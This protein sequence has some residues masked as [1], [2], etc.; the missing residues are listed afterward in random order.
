M[1]EPAK[2]GAKKGAGSAKPQLKP[3]PKTE[4]EPKP[5]PAVEDK[6]VV[7]S[8]P[9]PTAKTPPAEAPPAE[10]PPAEVPVS[11]QSPNPEEPSEDGS[12]EEQREYY[13]EDMAQDEDYFEDMSSYDAPEPDV[14]LSTLSGLF[15]KKPHDL[16]VQTGKDFPI[17]ITV[18][19]TQLTAKP[20][21]K[22]FKGKWLE[23][24]S[25]SGT[26]YKFEESYEE[27]KKLY[28]FELKVFKAVK[29]DN[30]TYRC[31]VCSAD[32]RENCTF[33]VSV[34]DAGDDGNIL[35]AFKRSPGGEGKRTDAGELDFSALLKK[36]EREKKEKEEKKVEPKK[37]E[38]KDEDDPMANIPPHVLEILRNA[39]PNEYE[40]IAFQHGITDLRGM[41]KHLKKKRVEIQKTDAF[42]R[43]LDNC[44]TVDR[45]Q[46]IKIHV[47]VSNPDLPVKWMKNG[48][49]IKPSAK[50]VFENIGL[51]RI[52]TINK[53]TLADDAEYT[54]VVGD[55]RCS[56]ELFV[57][58]PPVTIEKPLED[59]QAFVGDKVE[60]EVEVSEEGAQVVWTK[61][62]I[63]LTR[64]EMTKYRFR[65]DGKKH[66]LIINETNKEDTG[67]Y[68]VETNGG[69]CEA[70][71]VI[72]DK[73]LEVLQGIAD[74]TVKAAEQ[75]VFKCEVSDEK[76]TG[77]WLKNG[78]EI[79]PS[80]R[81]TMS[82]KGR[83]HKLVIDDVK[84][85]DE[86]DYTFVP[87]GYALSLSA[88]L[89]F[90]EV[91]IEYVPLEEPPKIHL[92][93]SGEKPLNTIT[94]VAGNKLRFDV[95][96]TGEPAPTVTWFKEDVE[97]TEIDGRVRIE[98][99]PDLSSFVIEGA[100]R[101][102]EGNYKIVV[103]N[104]SGEDAAQLYVKVVD[105]PDPPENIT[106]VG[107]GEDWADVVWDPPKYDGG[108]EILGYYIER[109]KKGSQR[110]MKMNFEAY[111]DTKYQSTNM[112]EGVL[113][114]IRIFAVNAIGISQEAS[115]TNPFMPIAPTSEPLHLTVEDVT[116]TT[117]TLKWRPPDRIGAG[118]I[119]G[120]LIEY[121]KEGTDEWIESNKEL[122][123]RCGYTA[124]GLPTGE[125][126][127]FRVRAVNIAGKSEP[128][129]LGQPVTIREIVQSPKIRLPRQL[130]QTYI[131]KVGEHVN[132]VIPFQGKP[133]P[134]VTWTKDGEPLDP[135]KVSVRTS[136]SDTIIFIRSSERSH[137]GKYD[138]SVKIENMV[139]CATVNIRIV[140]KPGPA[141][142]VMVKEVWGF[143]ALVEWQPPKDN[144]NSEITGYSIQKADKKTMEW[145]T[146]YEHNRQPRCTVSDLI[147]GNEYYFRVYSENIVGLSD[148]PGVSKNTAIIEKTGLIHKPRDYKEMDVNEAPKFL[149]PLIDR[150]VVAGY[151][152]ALNCAV[153]GHPKPKV[154]WMKNKME[155][156]DDPKFLMKH[157]QGVLTLN[158]RKPS[159]FDGG[160]Y[161]CKAIN[162]LGEAEVDCK[163]EVR[164]PQ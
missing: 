52:L 139:D 99:K 40:K 46:K 82:H 48:Q 72:E 51:K 157:N 103:T 11:P 140:D 44:Y 127:F 100:K 131:K 69:S 18:N 126:L 75:A 110:W 53:C 70:D 132:L 34:E 152:T 81:I 66:I 95:P 141:Q 2:P 134:I 88:K 5:V 77:R 16:R 43:K 74:L 118:G 63:E 155:I 73:K 68:G 85:E 94:V 145:F 121:C 45:H 76:V 107:V 80:K 26:R 23:L 137:S 58:E 156:K 128:A 122:V 117:C 54:C 111:T 17:K 31:E 14:D 84:P 147:M 4:K 22:W 102:D 116:D 135:K 112:I 133:R 79:R 37:K 8:P 113:Y 108:Q 19:G 49:V 109:K 42:T 153:R 28:H 124:K 123:E 78:V 71:L 32:N 33:S 104:P 96:I 97:F 1:P 151:S 101:E 129:T 119:D 87:D 57:K 160:T 114:E 106:I 98:P 27:A 20:T 92:D 47:E 142:A 7:P 6:E 24:G 86:A 60:L 64:D 161:T 39:K 164:V 144:G 162:D 154:I 138:L 9:A 21:V 150:V 90:L 158:I 62:G 67:R 159:P 55:E 30:G 146:V 10:A 105:V 148:N 163:L 93:C 136:E 29:A 36:T 143:N 35:K 25:K 149:T 120:Y 130:R 50:Y 12:K 38:K 59:Q 15:V 125:K 91:K 65:K 41:L 115:T 13:D 61:D 89:N 3:I 56:T 83:I